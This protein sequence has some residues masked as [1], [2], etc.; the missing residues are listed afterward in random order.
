MLCLM[1]T[2]ASCLPSTHLEAL[3][4]G[5]KSSKQLLGTEHSPV[6]LPVGWAGNSGDGTSL[7]YLLPI[8]G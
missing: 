5:Y 1:L 8:L 7:T 4:Q 6:E 2:A 3:A